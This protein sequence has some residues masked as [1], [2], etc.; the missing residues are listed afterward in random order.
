LVGLVA[1]APH[2][3]ADMTPFISRKSM[4]DWVEQQ[5]IFK[6]QN[7]LFFDRGSQF[8]SRAHAFA[9]MRVIFSSGEAHRRRQYPGIRQGGGTKH[10][11]KIRA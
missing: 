11:G 9:N 4:N 1:A 10:G 6:K 5:S 7:I 2:C 3:S 8:A